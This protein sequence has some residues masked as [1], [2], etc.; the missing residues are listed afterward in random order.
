MDGA[1][2]PGELL[3][4][5]RG[6]MAQ[7]EVARRSGLSQGLLCD[8]EHGRRRATV[9]VIEGYEAALGC[10]LEAARH[11][12]LLERAARVVES[13]LEG[14]TPSEKVCVARVMR[15]SLPVLVK[16]PVAV[17]SEAG[18]VDGGEA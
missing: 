8:V 4:A 17:P 5:A 13:T 2:A 6:D 14:L 18:W 1:K 10:T 11:A 12:E 3:R 7:A 15:D 16:P 9:R